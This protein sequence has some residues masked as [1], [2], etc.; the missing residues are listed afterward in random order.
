MPRYIHVETGISGRREYLITQIHGPTVNSFL[1]IICYILMF[2]H[3]LEF[4]A[5]EKWKIVTVQIYFHCP[6]LG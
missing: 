1:Y 3:C 4:S 5:K 2:F 6:F